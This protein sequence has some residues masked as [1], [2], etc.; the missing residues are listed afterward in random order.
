MNQKN[1]TYKF[2][3]RESTIFSL[4]SVI[5]EIDAIV[6]P[7]R[8]GFIDI[9]KKIIYLT[10]SDI[11]GYIP[12]KKTKFKGL[13]ID[14]LKGLKCDDYVVHND[15]GIGQ[16][17]GLEQIDFEGKKVECL[18]IVY[19]DND[20]VYLPVERLNQLERYIGSE[21]KPPKL[22][23][24]GSELWL[25]TKERVRKATEVLARDLINLY[26]RRRR[27]LHFQKTALKCR[28]LKQDFHLRKHQ[29][30]KRR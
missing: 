27:A 25:K 12:R 9:N 28:N 3:I 22:S 14:D 11:Y 17:K 23:K 8:E 30:R 1:Y 21:G 6:L 5:G 26:A 18:R 20:K 24:L 16:F 10:E 15:F 7:L 29:T 4:E 2:L 13:F 19:A